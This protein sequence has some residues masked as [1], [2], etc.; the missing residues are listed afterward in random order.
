MA[1]RPTPE[2]AEALVNLAT[3]AEWAGLSNADATPA[4][5]AVE[6]A[7]GQDAIPAQPP[8]LGTKASFLASCGAAP[9]THFRALA[10]LTVQ[11]FDTLIASWRIRGLPPNIIQLGAA[12]CTH[13]TA[14]C[15]CLLD[16][17]PD[18]IMRAQQQQL[19]QATIQ[20]SQPQQQQQSTTLA[21]TGQSGTVVGLSTVSVAEV[22]DQRVP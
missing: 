14:R 19:Q 2:R 3:L 4:V 9:E 15:L 13:R 6:A 7:E 8:F 5:E 21:V 11:D 20:A 12:K 22:V 1:L 10:S 17:W 16:M 18:E